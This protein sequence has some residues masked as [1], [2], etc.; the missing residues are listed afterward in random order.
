MPHKK[1]HDEKKGASVK[2]SIGNKTG[3]KLKK[4][5]DEAKKY[6]EKLRKMRGKK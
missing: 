6:M 3:M 4:G 2:K 5:S 1:G